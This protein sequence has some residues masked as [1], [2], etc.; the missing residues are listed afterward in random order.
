MSKA[1]CLSLRTNRASDLLR[2]YR[3][4]HAR[5]Q[6]IEPF[7]IS[8]R[9]NTPLTSISDPGALVEYLNQLNLKGDMVLDE[10]KR[11]SSERDSFRQKLAEAEKS[12][13]DAWDEVANL[14]R[15]EPKVPGPESNDAGEPDK[16]P[17]VETQGSISSSVQSPTM[18]TPRATPFSPESRPT[19]IQEANNRNEELFSYDSELPRL[20]SELKTRQEEIVELKAEVK[21]LK[22]DL[23]VA[24]ESTE[25]MAQSLEDATRELNGLRDGKERHET[26]VQEQRTSSEKVLRDLKSKLHTAEQDLEALRSEKDEETRTVTSELEARLQAANNAVVELQSE[27]KHEAQTLTEYKQLQEESAKLSSEI[28]TLLTPRNGT[29]HS[30]V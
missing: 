21:T 26:E 22:G 9:E 4:A 14:R 5:V 24:R 18:S 2:S 29:K 1:G 19:E 7:E 3:I 17:L 8:L 20:E 15:Q 13:K 12:T 16:S 30:T 25:S 11:V 10:L 28:S 6:L 27:R 23:A